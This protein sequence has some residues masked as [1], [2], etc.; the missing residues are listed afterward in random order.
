VSNIRYRRPPRL[1]RGHSAP[2]PSRNIDRR[3]LTGSNDDANDFAAEH[4]NNLL[5]QLLDGAKAPP[6][7]YRLLDGVDLL[8]VPSLPWM[9]R[10][11]V[12]MQ[13]LASIY[14]A[15]G[16]G[17]SFLSLDLCAAVAGGA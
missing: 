1:E 16:S 4:G 14:G 3:G 2:A 15:S 9:V 5:A 7:R 17:K 12:P 11:V 13:G 6:M 8:N 10:G